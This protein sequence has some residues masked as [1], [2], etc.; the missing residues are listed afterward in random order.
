MDDAE[1]PG[2]LQ[3]HAGSCQ[4]SCLQAY[5]HRLSWNFSA[6][7]L[8]RLIEEKHARGFPLLDLTISNPTEAF[9]HYPHEV[10]RRAL[11]NISDFTYHPAPAGELVARRAVCEYY[12]QRKISIAPDQVLL[13]ASS[14]ESYALLFKL[15]CD[16]GDEILAPVP[17]YPLFEFLAKLES[18]RIVPYPLR[19]DGAWFIDFDALRHQISPRTR[20]LVIVNP[21]NPTGSFLKKH[22]H[23]QILSIAHEHALPIVS[24]EVFMDYSFADASNRILSLT[25]CDS[26]LSFSLNGLSKSAGM[27]QMKLGWMVV[28]GPESDRARALARLELLLDTYL[29]VNTPVERALP[30]LLASGA[31]FQT[32]ISARLRINLDK[33]DHLL[34]ATPAHRLHTEGGWSAILQLP[35]TRAEHDWISLL[36]GAHNV[37]VHPGHFFDMTSE[38]YVVLSLIT[39]PS[40]FEE[41]VERM[42]LA[43]TA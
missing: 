21:N 13:T 41:G 2:S 28:N 23:D 36:T 35:S 14:S 1:A 3:C 27:P 11:S 24:D 22:E 19:Y 29:S 8:T 33:L 7:P 42:R 40:I 25:R 26:V 15:L 31:G 30:A 16:P 10:I 39:A 5:S 32:E 9:S 6:N 12:N 18:V 4:S 37:L 17:S 38:P 43:V 34:H 20:A